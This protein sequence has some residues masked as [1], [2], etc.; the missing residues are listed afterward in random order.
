MAWWRKSG[1]SR[2]LATQRLLPQLE[3]SAR[4]ERV[5][6]RAILGLTAFATLAVLGGT[7]LGRYA[8]FT[9]AV[10]AHELALRPFHGEPSRRE[11][12]ALWA[13]RRE[14]DVAQTAGRYDQV[15]HASRE[16]LQK[17]LRAGG[18]AP[19]EGLFRWANYDR[20][21]LFSSRVFEADDRGR[22][23][24]L[25][26]QTRSVWLREDSLVRGPFGM[27]LVPDTAEVRAAAAEAGVR[28]VDGSEQTTNSWGL[29][30]PE[31]RQDAAVRGLVLGDSFMQGLFIGDDETPPACL[32]RVL[33]RELRTSVCILNTGHFG[34]SPEQYYHTLVEYADRFRPHFVLVSVCPN[35]FGD[36]LSVLKGQGDWPEATHWL[37]AVQRFCKGRGIACVVAPIPVDVRLEGQRLEGFYPGLV[38]N[39]CGL[40]SVTYC[41]PF[42]DFVDE[43]LR[44]VGEARRKGSVPEHSLLYNRHIDDGHFSA[45]G[46]AVWGR[47]LGRRVALL[48]GS[49]PPAAL[50]AA[51][52]DLS[53][54]SARK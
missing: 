29:R 23:Y 46:A 49:D 17:L 8:V 34:Y 22:S 13:W 21:L 33:E 53:A 4:L 1:R 5:L 37:G 54:P 44:L 15:F 20:T 28:V 45:R 31:P 30:G 48:L 11:I 50:V 16:P 27:L 40:D 24:R 47:S 35:D 25:R 26:S 43:H 12:D 52:V 41:N 18:M 14:R 10:R 51:G 9:L 42:D 39:A 7:S 38:A 36:G 32:Q 3:R 19:G 6:R 2:D